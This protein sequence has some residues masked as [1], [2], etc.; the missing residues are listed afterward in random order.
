MNKNTAL[1][2]HCTCH[3]RFNKKFKKLNIILLFM[4]DAESRNEPLVS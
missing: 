2:F 4:L 3:L 1:S